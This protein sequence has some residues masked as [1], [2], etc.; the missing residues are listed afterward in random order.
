MKISNDL[1]NLNRTIYYKNHETG[2]YGKPP[3]ERTVEELLNFGIIILDKPEGPTSHQVASF[4]RDILNVKAGH[5]GTLDPKVSGVLPIG[6]GKATR[7]MHYLLTAGKEYVGIMHLH[8][9][10]SLDKIE[11]TRKKFIGEIEQLPPVRSA[12]K[13]K[14]R[15]RKIY[16]W[17][18]LEIDEQDILFRVGVEAGTYIRKLCH[19]F[20]ISLG[21]KAHMTQLRRTKVGLLDEEHSWNL[22][23][24]K[25]SYYLY[26][27]ENNE[28]LIRKIILPAEYGIQHLPKIW[29]NDDTVYYLTHG[30]NLF[31]PGISKFTSDV[32]KEKNVALF[33]LKN[34][35]IGIGIAK[36]NAEEILNNTKGLAVKIDAVFMNQDYFPKIEK[37][38]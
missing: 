29:V 20:G 2:K 15:K 13:R 24:L 3:E 38:S 32:E 33:T 16:Y 34:E 14:L 7:I 25:D 11:E 10:I 36:M 35:L 18:F 6:L 1:I 8:E 37:K 22:Y 21:T 23:D 28:Y 17:D 12:V 26:K 27:N 30:G 19:D 4:V 9:K 5:S 31:V